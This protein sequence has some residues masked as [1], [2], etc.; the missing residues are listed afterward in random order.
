ME[1]DSAFTISMKGFY[2]A[3]NIQQIASESAATLKGKMMGGVSR[4]SA[5]DAITGAATKV[6]DL[7]T[8]EAKTAQRN[9]QSSIDQLRRT[10]AQEIASKD[11][12]IKGQATEITET[13]SALTQSKQE[14]ETLGKKLS[15]I[16]DRIKR[17]ATFRRIKTN[18]DGTEVFA[19]SNINGAKMEK[20]VNKDGKTV[21]INVEQLDGSVR[22]TTYNPETG[23]PMRTYTNTG[24]EPVEILYDQYGR[25]VKTRKVNVKKVD[26]QKA[27]K[28]TVV[29][30]K[31][32][33]DDDGVREL[34]SKM[35]DGSIKKVMVLKSNGEV[36]ESSHA[37][38]RDYW[39]ATG[40]WYSKGN[41]GVRRFVKRTRNDAGKIVEKWETIHP[42][43]IKVV[44]P[45][46]TVTDDFGITRITERMTFPKSSNVKRIDRITVEGSNG[47]AKEVI[48]M[49]DGT[50]Y[51]LTDFVQQNL[52]GARVRNKQFVPT[53]G[54]KIAKDGTRTPF[55]PVL[56]WLKTLHPEY[57]NELYKA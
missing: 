56:D 26:A 43:G 45:Y 28:P 50:I 5:V 48:K 22:R 55:E 25:S 40:V 46:S 34:E 3:I 20:V 44:T 23:K 8:E 51:E 27:P 49:K 2:M 16:A 4:E 47:P 29:S 21:Q 18:P 52:S 36:I 7:M 6:A 42:S 33:R 17:A 38:T 13:K 10:H 11:T 9:F 12:F 32:L 35:S 41:D 30:T 15:G 37:S 24:K 54:V 57:N 53:K 19:K 31:I 1:I 14:N 39:A